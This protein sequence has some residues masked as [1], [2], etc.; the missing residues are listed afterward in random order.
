LSWL[1]IFKDNAWQYIRDHT[2]ELVAFL[3]YL[4]FT[5][6][7]FRG[8]LFRSG[9]LGHS[10]DW[11]IPPTAS[12]LVNMAENSFF[13]WSSQSF[14]SFSGYGTS[15]LLS[16]GVLGVMGFFGLSGE[17]VTKLLLVSSVLIGAFSMYCLV[18]DI[19]FSFHKFHVGKRK[20]IDVEF[21]SLLAGYFYALSPFSFW[22]LLQGAYTQFTAYSILPLA[23]LC[24]RK[25]IKNRSLKW[26]F[27][28]AL[29]LTAISISGQKL[30]LVFAILFLYAIFQGK[31][32]LLTLS[33]TVI[34]WVPLNLYW[35]LI[36]FSTFGVIATP[37]M[38]PRQL[39]I[40][41]YNIQY[42]TPPISTAFTAT[43]VYYDEYFKNALPV[44]MSAFWTVAI[45][46][47]VIMI[48][49]IPLLYRRN[50][51]SLFWGFIALLSLIF[52]TG[53]RPPLGELVTWLFVNLPWPMTLFEGPIHFT[54][55]LI[56]PYAILLGLALH[57][58]NAHA[59]IIPNSTKKRLAACI[60]FFILTTIWI[61]PFYS[62]DLGG[63][64]DVYRL[65]PDYQ[66]IFEHISETK[67]TDYRVL[68]L[69]MAGSPLYE[70]TEYQK[71]GQGGDPIVERSLGDAVI[72]DLVP[73][74]YAK[75]MGRSLEK[76]LYYEN[77][78]E[79]ASDVL[80][81]LNIKYIVLRRDVTPNF[82]PYLWN[83]T[84]TYNNLKEMK[85]L[86]LLYEGPYASLWENQNT[87]PRI[88]IA[89]SPSQITGMQFD[90][91][92][93]TPCTY[94]II[95]GNSSN[96]LAQTF[97]PSYTSIDQ[98]DLNIAVIGSPDG[99][100]KITLR[101]TE[102]GKPTEDT[103]ATTIVE[104]HK[105]INDGE[106]RWI[107]INISYDGLIPGQRYALVLNT[108][109]QTTDT[110]NTYAW[111]LDD[112]DSY[113]DGVAYSESAGQWMPID[114]CDFGF[115]TYSLRETFDISIYEKWKD[116]PF[117][118]F[119]RGWDYLRIPNE[120]ELSEL[121]TLQEDIL[122][123][124]INP[125]K[126]VINVNASKPFFII[127]SDVYDPNWLAYANGERVEEHFMY[128]GYMNVWHI[129]QTGH[130]IITLNFW[131]QSLFE[132]GLVIPVPTFTIFAIAIVLN[133][134][135]KKGHFHARLKVSSL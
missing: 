20:L 121:K 49:S 130:I 60:I 57:I 62:G 45:F 64:V 104:T 83:Y 108:T 66:Y 40:T 23:I 3:V 4:I 37:F 123:Q 32:G 46:T 53:S 93:L 73:N 39:S 44:S 100:L 9:T 135:R 55:L 35:I 5:L 113:H 24:F 56:L 8:L 88:Y 28:T 114:K 80:G 131:P 99:D 25:G 61:A 52:I 18:K 13:T 116:N 77:P 128:N 27:I 36:L 2:N 6:L 124:K 59:P 65:P 89:S 87:F 81:L 117:S 38:G 76:M 31:T 127:F 78:P 41:L 75:E 54:P 98:I 10:L 42:A 67:N 120:T 129:N 43:N 111:A 58:I 26:E 134:R 50:K 96:S 33:K 107:P 86:K 29:L 15:V 16:N 95:G 118:N 133:A 71:T 12:H 132:L 110:S 74:L 102:G 1:K 30:I 119:G 63:S 91:A 82:T 11:S 97:T 112:R 122:I 17:P 14:G 19:I 34:L 22:E 90:Q 103:L 21:P 109:A 48:F 105:L 85:G 70:K 101:T 79:Y 47:L 69:P 106:F 51:E 7:V 126:Y 125:T 72:A 84:L 115:K 94:K 92:E 68:Y